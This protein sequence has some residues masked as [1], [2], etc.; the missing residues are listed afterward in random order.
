MHL[1]S[2]KESDI[3]RGRLKM[4]SGI[5]LLLLYLTGNVQ[6]ESFH[7]IFHSFEKALHSHEEEKDPCHRAIYH[8]EKEKGCEHKTHFTPIKKCPLCHV[9]PFN[10]QHVAVVESYIATPSSE[11]YHF[12]RYAI[13]LPTLHVTLPARA[14]PIG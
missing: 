5:L 3:L 12:S 8:D 7:E 13:S 11:I 1:R 2:V 9:V 10:D 6:V 14:P 4:F